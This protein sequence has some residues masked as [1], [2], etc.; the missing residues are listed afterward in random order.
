MKNARCTPQILQNLHKKVYLQKFR[1][2]EVSHSEA[3]HT[4]A[5]IH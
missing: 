4:Q 5:H 2:C 3:T 1:E